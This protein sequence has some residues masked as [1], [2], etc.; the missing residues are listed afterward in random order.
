MNPAEY[1]HFTHTKESSAYLDELIRM[2]LLANFS[3]EEMPSPDQ[4]TR[5][6][7]AAIR[8]AFWEAESA[9]CEAL[10]KIIEE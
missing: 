7:A 8:R 10:G 2:T 6:N 1:E 3:F 9:L 5:D 4:W